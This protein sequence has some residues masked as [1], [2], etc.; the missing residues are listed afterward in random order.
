MEIDQPLYV[1]LESEFFIYIFIYSKVISIRL[2]DAESDARKAISIQQ[3]AS[4]STKP[5]SK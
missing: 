1:H 5:T 4:V 3:Y 2:S